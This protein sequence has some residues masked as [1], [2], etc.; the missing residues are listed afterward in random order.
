MQF[1]R[2]FIIKVYAFFTA[3]STMRW[4]I[5]VIHGSDHYG[6]CFSCLV[7]KW[8]FPWWLSQNSKTALINFCFGLEKLNELKSLSFKS[9]IFYLSWK[10]FKLKI[11]KSKSKF[12]HVWMLARTRNTEWNSF[13][14]YVKTWSALVIMADLNS[15]KFITSA[16]GGLCKWFQLGIKETT[17]A[18]GIWTIL[19][20]G[21]LGQF[22]RPICVC[23]FRQINQKFEKTLKIFRFIWKC[24]FPSK[25]ARKR[26]LEQRRKQNALG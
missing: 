11:W 3:E 19:I 1:M 25:K 18:M 9:I 7:K 14:V 15:F 20:Q 4:F 24:N 16:D 13:A 23:S 21:L 22:F 8:N 2:R 26:N 10:R 5:L 6:S 12:N 17:Y